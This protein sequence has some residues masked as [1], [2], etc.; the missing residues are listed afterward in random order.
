[1]I[2]TLQFGTYTFPN[3]T[4]EIEGHNMAADVPV[5][6]IV[7]QDGGVVLDGYL[8]PRPIRINGKLYGDDIDSMHNALNIMARAVHN[9]GQAANLL[10][11]SD[12]QVSARMDGGGFSCPFTKGLYEHLSE[13]SIGFIAA[14]PYAE[15]T[16]ATTTTGSRTNNSATQAVINN[17]NYPTNP[18]I[19]FIA[20]ACF[21]NDLFVQN[22]ANSLFFRFQGPMINGQTLVVD[23][24]AGCVLLQVGLTMVE[25]IS[26]F[27]GDLNF[28]I[29]GGGSNTLIIDAATLSYSIVSR[30]RWYF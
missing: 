1:M 19:T 27:S 18:V 3:Q 5:A 21:T 4:F 11:R 26:Y 25:A 13:I 8:A 10:Y 6:D 29:E 14:K 12:R 22:N 9:R 17:G 20:G 23:C 28:A 16:T 30:D 15:S 24:E 2:F 7:R